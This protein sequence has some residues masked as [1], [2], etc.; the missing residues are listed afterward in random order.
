MDN[1]QSL[2]GFVAV[3]VAINAVVRVIGVFRKGTEWRWVAVDLV[4]PLHLRVTTTALNGTV[5][6]WAHGLTARVS[7]AVDG[8]YSAGVIA[9]AASMLLCLALL[10]IAGVQIAMAMLARL[11]LGTTWSLLQW[12][13]VSEAWRML[14]SAN[15]TAQ[16]EPPLAD[17]ARLQ[18][19]LLA[20]SQPD[21][22]WL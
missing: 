18:R 14:G 17:S 22:Q 6:A 10:C 1:V 12:A 13:P 5:M 9:A 19:R 3:W 21:A 4:S 11:G 15:T 7:L 16:T 20:D 2:L 8:F